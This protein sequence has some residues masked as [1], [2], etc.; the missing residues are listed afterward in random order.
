MER[1]EAVPVFGYLDFLREGV[2]DEE[3]VRAE[4]E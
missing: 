1:G 3:A 4:K 2:A